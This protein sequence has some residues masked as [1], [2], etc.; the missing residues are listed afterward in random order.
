MICKNC[1]A[2]I[3]EDAVSCPKC[4]AV[5]VKDVK[6][7][8]L[9]REGREDEEHNILE[10]T[11]AQRIEASNQDEVSKNRLVHLKENKK[12][13]IQIDYNEKDVRKLSKNWILRSFIILIMVFMLA[14]GAYMFL[15]R[16]E[17]GQ[18][19]LARKFKADSP[20]AYWIVG[21]E[22]LNEG[23]IVSAIRAF[24]LADAKDPNNTD[25][26]LS[27]AS[28]YEASNLLDQAERIYRRIIKD[29]SPNR[30]ETYKLLVRMLNSQD[31]VAEAADVLRLAYEN[32]GVTEFHDQL[33]QILP[34]SPVVDL[35]G[36]RYNSEKYVSISSPQGYEIYYTLDSSKKATDGELY[37][38]KPIKIPEGAVILKAV[39]RSINLVSDPIEVKYVLVYPSPSS[40]KANLQPGTYARR[41]SVSLRNTDEKEKDVKIHYTIDGSVPDE[42]SPLY[43]GTPIE[44]PSG[45]V[46]LRAISINNRGKQSNAQEVGYKFDVKPYPEKRYGDTDLFNGFELGVTDIDAF[47]NQFG[48]SENVK[49]S[50]Y[51]LA[52]PLPSKIY[53]YPWGTAEFILLHNK[54]TLAKIDMNSK[55][56]GCPR[57]VGFGN[58]ENEVCAAYR[59]VGQKPNMDNTRGLYCDLPN[60]GKVD[61]DSN[62]KRYIIYT[63][64]TTK[65][66]LWTLEYHLSDLGT[67]NRIVHYYK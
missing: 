24:T 17:N 67:V 23:D 13:I 4:K 61:I 49:N 42:N 35:P 45:K 60:L 63:C 10:D 18:L 9:Q 59:D 41:I 57:S 15:K 22:F 21:E 55:L 36:G 58:T 54:W 32:T 20:Q 46:T 29:I 65:G 8:I 66:T 37:D 33:K 56:T 1:G 44:M 51:A 38:G 12:N 39:C 31:R 53:E 64:N 48:R 43:D 40:P 28:A 6:K 16:T 52:K 62:G 50:E 26:L 25:G 11:S 5:V 7:P 2:Y 34:E 27:L 14:I 3:S 19:I 47:F 30:I